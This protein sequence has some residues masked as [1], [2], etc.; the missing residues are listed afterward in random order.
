M[1]PLDLLSK[2]YQIGLIVGWSR[3]S[4]MIVVEALT[5]PL[6]FSIRLPG[7]FQVA[8][9]LPLPSPSTIG[10][11]FAYSYAIWEGTDFS[12]SLRVF[13]SNAWYYAIPLSDIVASSIILRR[14][15][16]L[17]VGEPF[18]RSKDDWNR[19]ASRLPE[20]VVKTLKEKGLFD[21]SKLRYRH[22]FLR[23]L[24]SLGH[25]HYW[26]YYADTF[27][28]A[29]IRRYAFTSN[30]YVAGLVPIDKK[31]PLSFTRL[32]DTESYLGIRKMSFVEEFELKKVSS[33]VLSS[34]AY[35][36]ISYRGKKLVSPRGDWPIQ[37][38]SAPYYLLDR[39]KGY[40]RSEYVSPAVL[41][42]RREI[43]SINGKDI[44]VFVPAEIEVEVISEVFV[45]TYNS[46]LL[47]R[48]VKVI[49]PVQAI[50]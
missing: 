24:K 1:I 21:R 27:F 47:G 17:Q 3:L 19:L 28:D 10:G 44:E 49:I 35:A 43:R 13:A 23:V 5:S 45:L 12:E 25:E 46:N 16:L 50:Q 2:L 26:K 48:K 20:N 42:I 36:F 14:S 41:P 4:Y 34:P 37:L 6:F 39:L 38:L 32:G 29:M 11:A 18:V 33:E 22:D 7:A 15:R 40:G 9:T 8:E 31:F 30:L